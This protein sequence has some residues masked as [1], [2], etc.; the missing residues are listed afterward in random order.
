M[1]P[2]NVGR[3]FPR[4]EGCRKMSAGF[5]PGGNVA[6]KCRQ[7]FSRGGML[8]ENV[9]RFFPGGE[10]CRKMSAGFFPGGMLPENAG[11]KSPRGGMQPKNAGRLF[12]ASGWP[13]IISEMYALPDS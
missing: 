2:E 11:N 13:V 9:G 10:C 12:P 8:P 1:L 4:G 7:V 6:G 3:F 5:F